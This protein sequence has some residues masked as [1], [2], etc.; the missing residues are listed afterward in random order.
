[1]QTKNLN[2]F[3]VAARVLNFGEA[4]KILNYSQSTVSDQIKNLEIELDVQ[5]FERIGR[6]IF[7][8]EEGKNL[9]PIADNMVCQAENIKIMFQKPEMMQ[10]TL[11]IAASEILSSYWLPPLLKEYQQSYPNVELCIS[12]G[13]CSKFPQWL[14]ENMVDI[15]FSQQH[16]IVLP[17][18]R[19]TALFS[20]EAV[21]IM[22][23]D[24]PL[25]NKKELLLQDFVNQTLLYPDSEVGY[26]W[27][28]RDILKQHNIKTHTVLEFG[29][30]ESIKQFAKYGLGISILP[31]IAVQKEIET[32]EL[33]GIKSK[34]IN[35]PI[36]AR[37]LF[38]KDKWLSPQ[39]AALEKL[40]SGK[41]KL[42][43]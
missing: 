38:H 27:E 37:M 43:Y 2:S 29:S 35:I 30:I 19:Q 32:G 10:G 8:T 12:I 28:L 33:V 5:L 34:V 4:A 41:I 36:T 40:V 1:M 22:S 26:P 15:A 39:L 25:S 18:I 3:L 21:F 14:Q 11:R 24:H 17:Q 20:W 13:D 6:R 31:E 42:D 23:K 16:K 9:L 7:L